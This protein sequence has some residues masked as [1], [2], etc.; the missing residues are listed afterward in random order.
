MLIIALRWLMCSKGKI[1]AVL[2]ADE[3]EPCYEDDLEDE[4]TV[5]YQNRIVSLQY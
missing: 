2:V 1:D 3:L 5:G 4:N